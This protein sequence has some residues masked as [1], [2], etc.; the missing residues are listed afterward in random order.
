[1][2]SSWIYC[3]T[4]IPALEEGNCFRKLAHTSNTDSGERKLPIAASTG[5]AKLNQLSPK[6]VPS[7][8]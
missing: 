7:D 5:T 4:L 2:T 6:T 1:M 8:H 3:P